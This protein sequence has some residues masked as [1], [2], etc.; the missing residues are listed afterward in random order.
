MCILCYI[1]YIYIPYTTL[2]L[3]KSLLLALWLLLWLH[4]R[5]PPDAS[6]SCLLS[7]SDGRP[8]WPGSVW[9]FGLLKRS[10]SLCLLPSACSRVKRWVLVEREFGLHQLYILF[11]CDLLLY[12]ENWIELKLHNNL[13]CRHLFLDIICMGSNDPSDIHDGNTTVTAIRTSGNNVLYL[14][15]KYP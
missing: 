8:L 1:F 6:L 5:P 3:V 14:C 9:G 2:L 11:C 7:L 15:L 13:A 10:L 12:K 4:F